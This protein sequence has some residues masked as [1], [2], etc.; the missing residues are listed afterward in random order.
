[1]GSKWW[2][3]RSGLQGTSPRLSRS[4]VVWSTP[5]TSPC[6]LRGP[7]GGRPVLPGGSDVQSPPRTKSC[8]PGA[9]SQQ[10]PT[11]SGRSGAKVEGEV[12][13]R[14]AGLRSLRYTND[15]D[16]GGLHSPRLVSWPGCISPEKGALFP[17]NKGTFCSA[18][19]LGAA[20][21]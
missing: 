8:S 19:P 1:M 15:S 2:V 12:Q 7:A 10:C 13:G 9:P 6:L 4:A 5:W 21:A 14:H 18:R 11:D 20:C 3:H 16:A 17:P